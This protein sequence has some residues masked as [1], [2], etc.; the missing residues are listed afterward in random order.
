M[1]TVVLAIEDFSRCA[2]A[3]SASGFFGSRMRSSFAFQ[4]D[5]VPIL[6]REGLPKKPSRSSSKSRLAS[7]VVVWIKRGN[8][9]TLEWTK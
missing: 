9:F 7:R 5:H 2:G 8:I 1:S 6:D 3:T 4:D